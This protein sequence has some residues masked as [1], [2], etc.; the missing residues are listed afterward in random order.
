LE[1]EI[2]PHSTVPALELDGQNW[3]VYCKKLLRAAAVQGLAGLLNGTRTKP[4]D[5]WDPFQ[6]GVWLRENTNAQYLIITTTP[7][8]IHNDFDFNMTAHEMFKRLQGLFEKTATT[9]GTW[10]YRTYGATQSHRW[11]RA[12]PEHLRDHVGSAASMATRRA[13]A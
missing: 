3:L 12:W 13:H 2:S 9:T 11:L 10:Y 6:T 7:P 4:D 1:S 8:A 5:L